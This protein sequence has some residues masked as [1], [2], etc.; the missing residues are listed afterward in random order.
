MIRFLPVIAI[1]F[2]PALFRLALHRSA[3][4]AWKK[5]IAGRLWVARSTILFLWLQKMGSVGMMSARTD[6]LF[7]ARQHV[8]WNEPARRAT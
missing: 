4:L 2:A 3:P 5:Y 6:A 7:I 1:F 8:A